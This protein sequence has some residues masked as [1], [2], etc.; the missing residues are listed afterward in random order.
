[1]ENCIFC[2]IIKGEINTKLKYEDEKVFAINDINSQSP[3]H[4]LIVPKE[5][6]KN[7]NEA[8]A[9]ILGHLLVI[10]SKL[11]AE[12]GIDESGYRIVV[13]CNEDGGQSVEHLHMHL[14]GG[15]QMN[16]PPG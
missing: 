1:M 15:R 3:I 2:K 9:D 14:L 6:I 4:L 12:Y 13:N 11:A 16:W 7:I 8:M 10:A 5:H